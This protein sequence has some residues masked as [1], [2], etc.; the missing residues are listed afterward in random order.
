MNIEKILRLNITFFASKM[1]PDVGGARE[2]LAKKLT[3][4]NKQRM[5]AD[6]WKLAEKVIRREFEI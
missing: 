2:K 3:N 4:K 6:D 5:L 1:W